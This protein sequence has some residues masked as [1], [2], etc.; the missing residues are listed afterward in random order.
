MSTKDQLVLDRL[1]RDIV[2]F[3][4]SSQLSLVTLQAIIESINDLECEEDMF[5]PQVKEVCSIITNSQPRMFP[6]DNLIILFEKELEKHKYFKEK[7]LSTKKTA[8][9]E[10]IKDA[11]SKK[12][13]KRV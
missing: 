6:I 11:R 5:G 3:Y 8:S 4:S 10:I 9:I 2:K 13:G 1:F 12:N 7:D